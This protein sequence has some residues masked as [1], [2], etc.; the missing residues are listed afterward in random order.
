M[1]TDHE[2]AEMAWKLYANTFKAMAEFTKDRFGLSRDEQ[3]FVLLQALRLFAAH[4]D[5][6]SEDLPPEL[7]ARACEIARV[8]HKQIETQKA[9]TNDGHE[10]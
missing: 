6:V 3:A 2:L 9:A 7:A 5:I 8:C 10:N 4:E 1:A